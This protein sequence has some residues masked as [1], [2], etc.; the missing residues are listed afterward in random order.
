MEAELSA[1][2]NQLADRNFELKVK[3]E[4]GGLRTDTS[5]VSENIHFSGS[6]YKVNN[7]LR[8]MVENGKLEAEHADKGAAHN[9]E[10]EEADDRKVGI[11][12][13]RA[14]NRPSSQKPK[15]S[16]PTRVAVRLAGVRTEFLRLAPLPRSSQ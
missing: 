6:S 16:S 14:R 10:K 11:T 4:D 8:K 7:D 15:N 5:W 3:T 1:T 9:A 12:T 13:G 2:Q